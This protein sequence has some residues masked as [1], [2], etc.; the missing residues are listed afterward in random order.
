MMNKNYDFDDIRK[1]ISDK[2]DTPTGK[3]IRS[4]AV[5]AVGIVNQIAGVAAGI[6]DSIVEQW[7]TFKFSLLL[8]G[9]STGLNVEK[10]LNQLYNFVTDSSEKA[11]H[12]ANL[13][14]QTVNAECPKACVIYG[15]ILADHVEK[16]T[17]FTH[18]EMIVCKALANATDYDLENFKTIM[19]KY[20]QPRSSGDR[21]VF[22][23]GF[24]EIESYAT[25]CDWAVFNRIFI[26]RMGEWEK[27]GE[28]TLDI[29]THYY[30]GNPAP[31][32][33][34]YIKKARQVWNYGS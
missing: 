9:L 33:L 6:G 30:T 26:S 7:N 21:V 24:S 12:V 25:T 16:N 2:I 11:I 32:L 8:N 20:T 34:E 5:G 14:K 10:R 4:G 13:F 27:L 17:A 28:G 19:E 18:D 29:S 23:E 22:P 31:V 3:L 15:L 1:A